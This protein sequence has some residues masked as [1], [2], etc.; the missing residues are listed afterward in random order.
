MP[1]SS[2]AATAFWMSWMKAACSCRALPRTGGLASAT[3][4][5]RSILA[6]ARFLHPTQLERVVEDGGDVE[7]AQPF[8]TL[9]LRQA[10]QVGHDALDAQ[11][12]SSMSST[13]A[14]A[15]C[16]LDRSR[17]R[18]L[19]QTQHAGERVVDL[20]GD[21]GAERADGGQGARA[22][23]E[24]LGFAQ[25]PVFSSTRCSRFSFHSMISVV[26]CVISLR[27]ADSELAMALN[28]LA[29]S[30]SSSSEE[31]SRRVSSLPLAMSCEPRRSEPTRPESERAKA[32][33]T[34]AATKAATPTQYEVV[35]PRRR[36]GRRAESTQRSTTT[37]SRNA[38]A[39][40]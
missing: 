32:P 2:I 27:A 26:C 14:R 25:L 24:I 13:M 39:G 34:S 36:A 17:Q 5:T 7:D 23:E 11:G 40:T 22:Q 33:P 4:L 3:R 21:A 10:Q 18:E 8:A 29:S 20:V 38:G 16:S 6:S 9:A 1:P 19:R 15:G 35:Q 28:D 37:P 12:L 30:P 31:T